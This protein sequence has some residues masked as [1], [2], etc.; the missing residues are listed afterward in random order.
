MLSGFLF[1]FLYTANIG[2]IR[3]DANE[4]C[5]DKLAWSFANMDAKD[6]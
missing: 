3:S 4:M 5:M 2:F 6:C 1:H